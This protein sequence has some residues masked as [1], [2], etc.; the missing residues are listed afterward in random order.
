ML[1]A[2]MSRD[3]KLKLPLKTY[4]GLILKNIIKNDYKFSANQTCHKT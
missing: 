2:E 1:V 3:T 4:N